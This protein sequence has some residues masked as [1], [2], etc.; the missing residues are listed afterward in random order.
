MRDLIAAIPKDVERVTWGLT[1]TQKQTGDYAG[2][3]YV[4]SCVLRKIYKT[5]EG[6]RGVDVEVEDRRLSTL[7]PSVLA[8]MPVDGDGNDSDEDEDER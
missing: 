7:Q 5:Y 8:L 6:L 3:E 2:H 1:N 4:K